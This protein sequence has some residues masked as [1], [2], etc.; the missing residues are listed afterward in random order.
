MR[1]KATKSLMANGFFADVDKCGKIKPH[2]VESENT[3]VES[4]LN[5]E[6]GIRS[7]F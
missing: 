7:A 5:V 4:G 6:F 1:G 3:N 2:R